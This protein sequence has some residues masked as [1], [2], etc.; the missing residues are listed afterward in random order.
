MRNHAGD[1]TWHESVL[2]WIH[3]AN[4]RCL[5]L[6]QWLR[7]K[8]KSQDS[9][10]G[11]RHKYK[12]HRTT[13][14]DIECVYY[15][16]DITCIRPVEGHGLEIHSVKV[17][18]SNCPGQK[19]NGQGKAGPARLNQFKAIFQIL[20]FAKHEHLSCISRWLP[21]WFH[22]TLLRSTKGLKLFDFGNGNGSAK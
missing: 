18:M 8:V 15:Q 9:R 6:A 16:T 14:D 5:Y 17:K 13:K 2:C 19:I 1:I 11:R 10:H 20:K 21:A 22:A 3:V 12:H 4:Q 7:T